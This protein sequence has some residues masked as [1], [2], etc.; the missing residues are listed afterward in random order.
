MIKKCSNCKKEKNIEKDFYHTNSKG[1]KGQSF[2]KTCFSRYCSNRWKQRK[3]DM[4]EYKGGIC[5][6]CKLQVHWAAF[7]FH[8]LN[9]KTKEYSWNKMRLMNIDKCKKELDK[10]ILLCS[11]CHRIE[12]SKDMALPE[13]L[14]SPFQP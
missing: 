6:H 9:K 4:I 1:K 8:H 12:H 2:C 3:L 7:D 10:C 13:E 14:E 5:V 11:N